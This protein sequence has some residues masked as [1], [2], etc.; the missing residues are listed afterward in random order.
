MFS[1]SVDGSGAEWV[2][3]YTTACNLTVTVLL[4]IEDAEFNHI[5]F[6]KEAY[7]SSFNQVYSKLYQ[8]FSLD[9][10]WINSSCW[11]LIRKL[12]YFPNLV[13]FFLWKNPIN[14][15]C[16]IHFEGLAFS[17]RVAGDWHRPAEESIK[18]WETTKNIVCWS[19]GGICSS[20]QCV[21]GFDGLNKRLQ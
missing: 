15:L 20:C 7:I 4:H 12:S 13:L 16:F 17:N 21:D 2:S 6:N 10:G 8:V 19:F 5:S 9:F 14:Y 3:G 11:W 1:D 18:V